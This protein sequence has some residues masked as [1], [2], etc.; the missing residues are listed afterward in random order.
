MK[1]VKA[2]LYSSVF[3]LCANVFAVSTT[4]GD[5]VTYTRNSSRTSGII[6]GA[7]G[8]LTVV[9]VPAGMT[10][11][12][13]TVIK[14]DYELNVLIKGKQKGDIGVCVPN[15][16]LARNFYSDMKSMGTMDF[17]AF[18][19]AHEGMVNAQGKTCNAMHAENVDHHFKPA[20]GEADKAKVMWINKIQGSIQWVRDLDVQFKAADGVKVLGAVEIDV[21]G[22]SD[23]GV[24]FTVGLDME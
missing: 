7:T 5:K 8:A 24:S 14:M 9:P 17:G 20:S 19:L 21:K 16:M 23:S 15:S 11:E 18:T 1:N 10:C 13:G 4:M 22:V 6:R 3:A 12:N 2:L